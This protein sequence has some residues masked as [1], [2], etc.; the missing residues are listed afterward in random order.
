MVGEKETKIC[1]AASL[2]CYQ[3]AEEELFGEDVIEG[4]KDETAKAFRIQCNCLSSCNTILYDAEVAHAKFDWR[5][6]LNSYNQKQSEELRT[7]HFRTL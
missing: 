2:K 7:F 1:G 3:N 6:L 4:L 5:A